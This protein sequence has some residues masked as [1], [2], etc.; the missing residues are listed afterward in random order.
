VTIATKQ[1]LLA[2]ILLLLG[3]LIFVIDPLHPPHWQII[4]GT[5]AG[6]VMVLAAEHLRRRFR[7]S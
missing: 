1:R 4:G 3:A 6:V 2:L 5:S 7:H